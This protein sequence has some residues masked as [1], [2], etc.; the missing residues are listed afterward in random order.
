MN[1]EPPSLCIVQNVISNEFCGTFQM[2]VCEIFTLYA[3]RF[4]EEISPF[5]QNIIQAVWQLV[6]QTG[7]ETRCL[8]LQCLL[9]RFPCFY[10]YRKYRILDL[11]EWYVLHWNSCQLSLRNLTMKVI[12]SEKEY[13]RQLHVSIRIGFKKYLHTSFNSKN[14]R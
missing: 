14:F 9:L 10:H 7:N 3:Q 2:E 8:L 6:V 1:H 4:E 5:M 11:M 13:C 12:L